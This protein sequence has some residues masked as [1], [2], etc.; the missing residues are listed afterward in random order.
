[1]GFPEIDVYKYEAGLKFYFLKTD[2][3]MED[4]NGFW[5]YWSWTKPNEQLGRD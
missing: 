1:M 2:I 5:N 3:F 4:K